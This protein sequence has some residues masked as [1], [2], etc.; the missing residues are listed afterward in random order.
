VD[1]ERVSSEPRE[2]PMLVVPPRHA[3]VQSDCHVSLATAGQQHE[4]PKRQLLTPENL[5]MPG[6]TWKVGGDV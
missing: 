6:W 4:P 5:S 1:K 3:L 2:L